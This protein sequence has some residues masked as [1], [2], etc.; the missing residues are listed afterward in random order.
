[1][2]EMQHNHQK[3]KLILTTQFHNLRICSNASK[4]KCKT[5]IDYPSL[6]AG[7]HPATGWNL[8]W[9][10]F[11]VFHLKSNNAKAVSISMENCESLLWK[12]GKN[13]TLS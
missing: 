7:G 11:K 10:Y 4:F 3:V 6:L 8:Y 12:I 13:C 9:V 1:M 5:D 2:I